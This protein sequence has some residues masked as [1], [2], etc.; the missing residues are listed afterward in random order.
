MMKSRPQEFVDMAT[1]VNT[2]GD[3]LGVIE[4]ISLRILK[5]QQGIL[6]TKMVS[7]DF[8]IIFYVIFTTMK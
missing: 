6:T 1:Y 3:K 5:E 8:T 7:L 2:L 4:R